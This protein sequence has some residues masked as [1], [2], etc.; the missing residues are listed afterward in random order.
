M[1]TKLAFKNLATSLILQLVL[2]LSGFI[3]P[4]FFTELYGSSMNGLVNSIS[5]FIAYLNLVEAGIS[6]SVI[7]SLYKPLADKN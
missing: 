2:A 1:R 6:S 5:Q 3:I 4:R 7:V